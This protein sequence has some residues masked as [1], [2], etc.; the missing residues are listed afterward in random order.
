MLTTF[1]VVG[2]LITNLAATAAFTRASVSNYPGGQA[3][4]SLHSD[5]GLDNKA[6]NVYID[7]LGAQTGASLFFQSRSP[8]FVSC[9]YP[10]LSQK[11]V[12]SYHKDGS[13]PNSTP[14]THVVSESLGDF[15]PS[16]NATRSL[17]RFP[18]TSSIPLVQLVNKSTAKDPWR[19]LAC[20]L[21]LDGWGRDRDALTWLGRVML[22]PFVSPKLWIFEK[23]N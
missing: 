15:A 18:L 20:I 17:E 19:P 11:T 4:K 6:V 16:F 3:L 2:S 8:P 10:A 1:L 23:V 21:G 5:F 14:F 13:P 22:V 9:A 7:D 12:W